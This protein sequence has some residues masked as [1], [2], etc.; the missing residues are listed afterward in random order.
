MEM[1]EDILDTP[2]TLAKCLQSPN[3]LRLAPDAA[4][5]LPNSRP[6]QS[7]VHCGHR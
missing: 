6:D 2:G 5:T 3:V 4:N 7:E 1:N